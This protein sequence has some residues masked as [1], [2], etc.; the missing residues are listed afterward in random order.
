MA[1]EFTI[2][3]G[4]SLSVA[5]ASGNRQYRSVPTQFQADLEDLRGPTPGHLLVATTGT[6]VSLAQLATPG[7]CRVQNLDTANYVTLGIYDGA[8]YFPLMEIGPEEFYV[9]KLYR[10]F[11]SEFVGT[12]TPSDVNTLRLKADTAAC[13]VLV[14]AFNR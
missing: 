6:D 11:G 9:F 8:S 4:L 3:S 5:P 10:F 14:E 12:G 7:F 13:K 2:T 1:N